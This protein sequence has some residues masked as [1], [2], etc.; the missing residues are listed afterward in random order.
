MIRIPY[1]ETSHFVFSNFSPHSVKRDGVVYPTAEHAYH[2]AKFDDEKIKDEIRQAGSP[3][4]AYDLGK[5]YKAQ[6]K[7]NWDEIK[8]NELYN[9]VKEK[10]T[11]HQEVKS[12][13]LATGT[14]E[15]VEENPN[16]DFW[17]SGQD[18]NGQNH[19]GKI[20]MKI[21]N[22]VKSQ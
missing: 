15:I 9:I 6:R 1:Y 8:V 7:P 14:E 21:R 19:M 18:G 13:L 11:Q 2:A 3:L 16:D 20:I 12:A 5:K 17:G 22:E 10:T 4:E